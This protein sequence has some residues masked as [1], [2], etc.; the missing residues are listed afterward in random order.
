MVSKEQF[1]KFLFALKKAVP[2]FSPDVDEALVSIWYDA[3][4]NYTREDLLSAYRQLR[5]HAERFPSIPEIRRAID[6][7]S[8]IDPVAQVKL[9]ISKTRWHE[10]P[11]NMEPALYTAVQKFGG[12]EAVRNWT[13][14]EF[15][16]NAMTL[17]RAY[18]EAKKLPSEQLALPPVK[19]KPPVIEED[20]IPAR[21]RNLLAELRNNPRLGTG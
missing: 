4:K 14:K 21:P 6:G 20:A 2:A 13:N 1:A 8:W 5:D 9:L 12:W 3:L 17:R 15:E 18:K 19:S 16:T 7:Q 11:D 10:L